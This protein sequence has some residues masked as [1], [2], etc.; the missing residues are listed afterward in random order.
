MEY[1]KPEVQVIE[2]STDAIATSVLPSGG[3]QDIG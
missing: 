2:F 3:T 1:V